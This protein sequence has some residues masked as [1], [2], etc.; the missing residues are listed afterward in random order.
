MLPQGRFQAFLRARSE[1]RHQLLQQLFRTGRFEDV[2]RWLRDRRLDAAPRVRGAPTSAV[3][4]L[5][6]RVSEATDAASRT[7]GTSTTCPRRPAAGALLT[8]TTDLRDEAAED[9]SARRARTPRPSPTPSPGRGRSSRP[10][11]PC[12]SGGPGVDAAAR[13]AG[14]ARRRQPEAT[15]RPGAGSTPRAARAAVAPVHRMALAATS[16]HQ[17]AAAAAAEATGRAADELG[18]LL[19]DADALERAVGEAV[20][21]AARVRAAL[22]RERVLRSLGDEIAAATERRTDPRRAPSPGSSPTAPP[23]PSTSPPCEPTWP[24]PGA[25]PSSWSRWRPGSRSSSPARGPRRRSCAST[26]ELGSPATHR[27]GG[28]RATTLRREE[29]LDLREARLD[30]MAAEIAGALA[31]GACCPVCGSADHP[32]KASPAPGAPDAT[33][34]KAAHKAARRRQGDRARPRR[35]RPRPDDP[36]RGGSRQ[37][38][39]RPR[40][41]PC[42][43]AHRAA[44]RARPGR[45]GRR[46]GRDA[47]SSGSRRRGRPRP[48]REALREPSSSS[49]P[50]WTTSVR[51]RRPSSPPC[52]AELDGPAGRQ[53]RHLPGDLLEAHVARVD[54]G[55][56]ACAA[57]DEPAAAGGPRRGH[58]RARSRRRRGRLRD[59]RRGAGRAAAGDELAPLESPCRRTTAGWPR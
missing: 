9:A 47:S 5:V 30:G 46:A 1:E 21:A 57:L 27:G 45:G 31:V 25:P 51:A 52:S 11:V 23:C 42:A 2:E 54:A 59:R 24:T 16:A 58:P 6:S 37:R 4:D 39:R 50:A 28:R 43:A 44:R 41:R 35:A 36:A 48:A 12:S 17:R 34:E 14:S 19:V 10:R 55:R 26:D 13:R 38:R 18:L 15:P 33:A 3:A 40:Q 56:R 53:R 29:W 49:W 20:D 8:W 32:H 22:P 7:T